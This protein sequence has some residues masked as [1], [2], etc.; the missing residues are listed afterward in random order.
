MVSD[1]H[2]CSCMPYIEESRY[3][4]PAEG[5]GLYA[6]PDPSEYPAAILPARLESTYESMM[7]VVTTGERIE[8]LQA[9]AGQLASGLFQHLERQYPAAKTVVVFTH[10]AMVIALGEAV[11][12]LL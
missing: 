5:T 6:S 7:K 8:A 9:R 4:P 10:A 11:C 2:V 12:Q 3:T 1:L